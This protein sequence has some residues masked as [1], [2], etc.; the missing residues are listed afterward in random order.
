VFELFKRLLLVLLC[1][2]LVFSLAACG[3]KEGYEDDSWDEYD[4][5]WEEEEDEEAYEDE[6]DYEDVEGLRASGYKEGGDENYLTF[7]EAR[8]KF[9]TFLVEK[10]LNEGLVTGLSAVYIPDARIFHY[11]TPLIYWGETLE[12][13]ELQ[14]KEYAF[15]AFAGEGKSLKNPELKKESDIHY[16]MTM[17]TDEDEKLFMDVKYYPDMDALR[18]EAENNGEKALVFEYV[19]IDGGY[20]SQYY[21]ETQIGGTYGE[22]IMG[23]CVFRSYFS[24]ENG[25]AARFD[26]AEIPP[27]IIKNLPNEEDFIEDATH[28]ISYKDGKLKGKLAGESF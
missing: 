14:Y 9:E 25:S 18:L 27:S 2:S 8:M 24:G 13:E 7:L 28:W 26:N 4:E 15:L 22:K 11:L 5:E 1:V 19:K 6:E 21:C 10:A 17:E 23:M 3:E 20:V 12:D 16:T